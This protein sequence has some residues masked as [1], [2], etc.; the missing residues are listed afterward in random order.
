MRDEFQGAGFAHIGIAVAT[1]DVFRAAHVAKRV[2]R[3]SRTVMGAEKN[4]NRAKD[5]NEKK[6]ERPATGR[7]HEAYF[8]AIF[9]SLGFSSVRSPIDR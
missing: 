4:Q 5:G 1:C 2:A 7:V 8:S 6:C 9:L 3:Q